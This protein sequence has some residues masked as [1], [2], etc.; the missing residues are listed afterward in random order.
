M[1]FTFL[2][3][4]R[5]SLLDR[6]RDIEIDSRM[7]RAVTI[8]IITVGVIVFADGIEQIRLSQAHVTEH[9]RIVR[10]ESDER[11]MVELRA[12][13]DTVAKLSSAA[14][15]VRATQRS[16]DRKAAE[17]SEIAAS[18]PDHVWLTSIHESVSGLVLRGGARTYALIGEAME[19]LAHRRTANA[20]VLVSS[21]V[22]DNLH[23]DVLEYE[24]HL[25]EGA[26]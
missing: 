7:Q 21:G 16:G 26:Q 17:L 14:A 1:R 15:S 9:D 10:L 11:H 5:R 12:A 2:R 18:L 25:Q 22:R 8:F 13:A 19:R 6:L 24:V 20:P 4:A 23:P 3:P